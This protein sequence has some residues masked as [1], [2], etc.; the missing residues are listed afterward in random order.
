MATGMTP[1]RLRVK[2]LRK[3]LGWTQDLLAEKT[4][5]RRATIS[6]IETG[7][8]KGIDFD[9]LERLARALEVDAGYLI[10]TTPQEKKRGRG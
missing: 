4:G 3:R 7:E 5:V 9:T 1:L 2:E 6:A 10:V 8:S